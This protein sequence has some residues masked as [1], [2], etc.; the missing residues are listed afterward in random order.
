MNIPG[1]TQDGKA[2]ALVSWKVARKAMAIFI[3][4]FVGD[5]EEFGLSSFLL[6]P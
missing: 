6:N 2:H 4:C 5:R 1:I 3:L